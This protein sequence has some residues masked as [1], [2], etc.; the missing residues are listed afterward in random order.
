M[1]EQMY[2]LQMCSWMCYSHMLFFRNARSKKSKKR[3]MSKVPELNN[4]TKIELTDSDT[5]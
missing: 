2:I 4:T 1:L 3:K 5:P